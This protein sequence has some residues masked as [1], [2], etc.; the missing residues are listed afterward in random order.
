MNDAPTFDQ[1]AGRAEAYR[2][3]CYEL[4]RIADLAE[5]ALGSDHLLTRHVYQRATVMG[6]LGRECEAAKNR[7]FEAKW[8][9][10]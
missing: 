4:H 1:L 10:A 6:G 3:A 8:V 5:A 9:T 7:M 2:E